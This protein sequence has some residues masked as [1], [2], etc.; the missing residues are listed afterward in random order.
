MKNNYSLNKIIGLTVLT[1][2]T[3]RTDSRIKNEL[4]PEYILFSNK[5]TF[6]ELQ[7]QDHYSYHDFSLSA[8]TINVVEDPFRWS[9]IFDDLKK[10]PESNCDI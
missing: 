3:Y 6:I 4:V 9:V 10:Y 2:R 7:E 1:I 5:K 8:R